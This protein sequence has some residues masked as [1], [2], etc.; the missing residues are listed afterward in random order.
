MRLSTFYVRSWFKSLNKKSLSNNQSSTSS[1]L[2]TSSSFNKKLKIQT[3]Q[4]VIFDKDGTLICFHSMWRDWVV[5]NVGTLQTAV[6]TKE[7]HLSQKLFKAVG[8]CSTSGRVDEFGLLAFSPMKTIHEKFAQIL[9]E[10][11]VPQRVAQELIEKRLKTFERKGSDFSTVVP[12]G[13]LEYILHSLKNKKIKV[14]VCTADSR[15]E[16]ES[17]LRDLRIIHLIDYTLCGDDIDARPKPDPLNIIHVC[18]SLNVS[19]EHTVMVG[20]TIG[21]LKMGRDAGVTTVGVLSGVGSYQT[22]GPLCDFLFN[23][24][25]ESLPILLGDEYSSSLSLPRPSASMHLS[26]TH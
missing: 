10:E 14:A 15:K 24:V 13:D 26:S 22:L 11:G 7:T 3:P 25:S 20:D 4:L 19:P 5:R 9:E 6:D 12:L 16:T 23:N 17:N 1:F 21:D 2:H 18:N 8:Y